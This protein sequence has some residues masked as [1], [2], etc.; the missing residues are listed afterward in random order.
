MLGR[1]SGIWLI[2]TIYAAI[3]IMSCISL[4]E[5]IISTY[6]EA[7]EIIDD[8]LTVEHIGYNILFDYVRVLYYKVGEKIFEV[9][10]KSDDPSKITI[11]MDWWI[12]E[13]A[14]VHASSY[15]VYVNIKYIKLSEYRGGEIDRVQMASLGI[16]VYRIGGVKIE[17]SIEIRIEYGRVMKNFKFNVLIV[18]PVR[19][20]EMA[21]IASLIKRYLRNY[22][23]IEYLNNVV[24]E[25]GYHEFAVTRNGDRLAI[26]DVS[27]SAWVIING[28]KV[29]VMFYVR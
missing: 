19:I 21:R 8:T 24:I 3:I 2:S 12:R 1:K 14:G 9:A 7:S 23:D 26:I 27:E 17:S 22:E 18:H 15:S 29:R 6:L 5:G 11:N 13:C 28:I 20:Y 25:K 4:R 10:N 16:E